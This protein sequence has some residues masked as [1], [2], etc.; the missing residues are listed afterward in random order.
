MKKFTLLA[1]AA[2][3]CG[4]AFAQGDINGLKL[5]D[6]KAAVADRHYYKIS[7]MRAMRLNYTN[8]QII[9]ENG[10]SLSMDGACVTIDSLLYYFE[11]VEGYTEDNAGRPV[12]KDGEQVKIRLTAGQDGNPYMGLSA[13]GG[14]WWVSFSG[15]EEVKSPDTEYWWFEDG[16]DNGKAPGT[17][18]IHNAVVEGII[19]GT[20]G[21]VTDLAGYSRANMDFKDANMTASRKRSH[22]YYLLP[23]APAFAV[24]TER[25]GGK[26]VVSW[27]DSIAAAGIDAEML[28]KAYAFCLNDTITVKGEPVHEGDA[29]NNPGDCL[30]MNNYMNYQVRGAK[31]Y[32][33]GDTVK[34]DDGNVQ[35]YR[36]G[37]A[38]VDRT[39][40]PITDNQSNTNHW[41][42]NGSIFF[43]E[44][45]N[46]AEAVA[47]YEA[48]SGK[49]VEEL[50]KSAKAQGKALMNANANLVRGWL[51]LSNVFAEDKKP[52]LQA[53]IAELEAWN[54]EGV[55]TEI[56]QPSDL[57]KYA[58]EVQTVADQKL[59]AAAQLVGSGCKV[60]FKNMLALRDLSD[61]A[62][63]NIPEDLVPGNAYISAGGPITARE[64][65]QV[66]EV[67]NED[68]YESG[69]VPVAERDALGDGYS[70]WT[71]IPIEGSYRFLLYNEATGRYIRKYTDMNAY[72]NGDEIFEDPTAVSEISWGTTTNEVEAAPFSLIGCPDDTDPYDL[73]NSQYY[74]DYVGLMEP[75]EQTIENKVRLE[76]QWTEKSET[77]TGAVT[78][79]VVT[80]NIHRGTGGSAYKFINWGYTENTWLADSNAFHIEEG[81]LGSINEVA[82]AEK[83]QN[84]GIYDLQGRKVAKAGKGLYIINGVKTLCK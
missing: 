51:H 21:R 19:S 74:E 6:P 49:I 4:S 58:K 3:T 34:D 12:M 75:E 2:L 26:D 82:A 65:G 15:Q 28:G 60:Y 76:A 72:V 20:S 29:E 10:D 50:V 79:E 62:Q 25:A 52:Q 78:T 35:Y 66:I 84:S 56:K 22:R 63:E 11:G 48:Y 23:V 24:M 36:Y 5:S 16:N 68:I 40:T 53:T 14:N 64:N 44:E 18:Y 77:S 57:E 81:T 47:A 69:I 27:E 55:T 1:L 37:F 45:A 38:G 71:I 54:G 9:K 41:T 7:N 43:F 8:G 17:L 39:W 30:D 61:A 46:T 31:L 13:L 80:A 67:E 59:A 70:L 32:E 83:V 42:N 73:E 33:N